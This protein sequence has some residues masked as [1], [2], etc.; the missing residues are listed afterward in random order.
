MN[1]LARAALLTLVLA[2]RVPAQTASENVAAAQFA[3]V[4]RAQAVSAVQSARAGLARDPASSARQAVDRAEGHIRTGNASMAAG[5]NQK[6]QSDFLMAIQALRQATPALRDPT[7][8]PAELAGFEAEATIRR[9]QEEI[10]R[11]RLRQAEEML[12]R[13]RTAALQSRNPSLHQRFE[14][15]QDNLIR[16]RQKL[17]TS[18]LSRFT[19]NLDQQLSGQVRPLLEETLQEG[20]VALAQFEAQKRSERD[21]E[22]TRGRVALARRK[23]ANPA[24]AEVRGLLDRADQ[25]VRDSEAASARSDYIQARV[26]MNSAERLVRRALELERTDA[27]DATQSAAR[28]E[29]AGAGVSDQAREGLQRLRGSLRTASSRLGQTS[30]PVTARLLVEAETAY[31]RAEGLYGEGNT[32]QCLR[33]LKLVGRLLQEAYGREDRL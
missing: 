12:H 8:T 10:D 5:R 3:L 26:S 4:A 18:G 16:V 33:L 31:E 17:D 30:D 1:T 13:V 7:P 28:Q 15:M 27:E 20:A 19:G 14:R 21:L 32:V 2:A 11:R 25:H 6:A 23:L 22:Q 9:R 24:S 29:S